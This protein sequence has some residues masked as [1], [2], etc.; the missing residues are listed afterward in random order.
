MES[1]YREYREYVT[2]IAKVYPRDTCD[3]S[4]PEYVITNILSSPL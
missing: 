4:Y 2:D 1:K 3:Q